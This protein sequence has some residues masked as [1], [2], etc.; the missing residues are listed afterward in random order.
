VVIA[1]TIEARDQYT[2]GHSRDVR[3]YAVM[4]SEELGLPSDKVAVIGTAALLHDIGKIG[5]P[6][7]V[8]NKPGRLDSEEWELIRGHP[9]LS[10]TI[11]GHVP[12]L[13]PCLAAVLHHHERWDGLG[14]PSGLRGESIPLEARILAVADAFEAM[15][16][17]RPYRDRM[18]ISDALEELRRCANNE[19][20]PH[21][22]DVFISII[23]AKG[24]IIPKKDMVGKKPNRR[25]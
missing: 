3:R 23:S 11:I 15:T 5:I 6:D 10:A 24:E 14:Y 25:R 13:T 19:F 17:P 8:L 4:L 18:S 7:E 2:Y 9:K 16:S 22:V 1:S 12:S 21:L 20:D